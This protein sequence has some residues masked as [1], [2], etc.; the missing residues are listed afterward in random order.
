MAAETEERETKVAE[1][2]K[3]VEF[4]L[5]H[6]HHE[7]AGENSYNIGIGFE[8]CKTSMDTFA[9]GFKQGYHIKLAIFD[10]QPSDIKSLGEAIIKEALKI[11]M[12]EK[13]ETPGE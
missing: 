11:E 6:C 8:D 3:P 7:F 4:E 5:S 2:P 10:L 12:E 1:D 9:W 13:A